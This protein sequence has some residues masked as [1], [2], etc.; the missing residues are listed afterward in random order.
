MYP[1]IFFHNSKKQTKRGL[2]GSILLVEPS[3]C[4]LLLLSESETRVPEV[5]LEILMEPGVILLMESGVDCK[6]CTVLRQY[7]REEDRK[8]TTGGS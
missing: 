3:P 8:D 4:W 2:P 7:I 1:Y 5:V 6:S